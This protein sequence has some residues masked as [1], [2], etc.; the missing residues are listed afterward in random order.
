MTY[1]TILT[2]K[3]TTTIPKDIRDHLGIKPGM[4]VSFTRN[5]Y[6]EYVVGREQ[7]IQELRAANK[8]ALAKAKTAHKEYVSGAGYTAQVKGSV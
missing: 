1:K 7:T 3:G 8:Q 4:L 2:D 5:R 6:G